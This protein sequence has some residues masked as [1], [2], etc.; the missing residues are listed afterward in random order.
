MQSYDGICILTVS[1]DYH[2]DWRCH[3]EQQMRESWA[4]NRKQRSKRYISLHPD[5]TIII[6]SYD[7]PPRCVAI[8]FQR[9]AVRGHRT[10]FCHVANQVVKSETIPLT[11]TNL[12]KHSDCV[13]VTSFIMGWDHVLKSCKLIF[14][15]VH[16][17]CKLHACVE[18]QHQKHSC[19]VAFSALVLS[20]E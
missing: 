7:A 5:A 14:K 10:N 11:T 13:H 4:C 9:F 1:L 19:V 2:K 15:C 3:H 8:Q 16:Q 17:Q 18:L 12:F 20:F 6:F